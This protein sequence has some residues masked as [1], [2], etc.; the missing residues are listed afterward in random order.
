MKVSQLIAALQQQDPEMEVLRGDNS[1][2]YESIYDFGTDVVFNRGWG[3]IQ[4]QVATTRI[5]VVLS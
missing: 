1:G 5:V 4:D 3:T 2:G